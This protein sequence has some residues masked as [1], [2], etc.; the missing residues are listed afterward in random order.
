MIQK[1]ISAWQFY[2]LTFGPTIG[3]SILVTPAGL[4]HSA[5]EDAW[6]ASLCGM[7]INMIMV[8]LYIAISRLYPGKT[9]F[10]ILESALG[11]KEQASFILSHD[12]KA[13]R[14]APIP[15]RSGGEEGSNEDAVSKKS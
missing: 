2:I 3:T 11:K 4:A 10:E 7:L 1:G 14:S 15:E 5:R 13:G 6:M 12:L 8:V 9:I